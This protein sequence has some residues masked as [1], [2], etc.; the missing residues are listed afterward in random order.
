MRAIAAAM[1][2]GAVRGT[3]GGAPRATASPLPGQEAG[4]DRLG[5]DVNWEEEKE[6]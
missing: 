5:G 3:W 1:G 2:L 4:G 6:E